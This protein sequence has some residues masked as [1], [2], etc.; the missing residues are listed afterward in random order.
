[1]ELRRL[2]R[3]D[4]LLVCDDVGAEADEQMKKPAIMKAIQDSGNDDESIKI[5]WEVIQEPRERE[6][7][8]RERK[9]QERKRER[10]QKY[11]KEK[12]A[13][14]KQIQYF[15][16]LKEQRQR[17]SENSVGSTEQENEE[18]S[19]GFS[20]K[21]D[22]KSSACEI[23]CTFIGERKGLAAND[24]LVAT[25]AVKG[26]NESDEVL[27]QQSTV[28]TARPAVNEL[29]QSPRVCVA[30]NVNKVVK[31]IQNNADP[32]D[33]STHVE[34]DLRAEG[35]CQLDDAV[36]GSTQDCEPLSLRED[37]CIV[38]GSVQRSASL[39]SVEL[40]ASRGKE[41][42][43]L[44]ENLSDCAGRRPIRADEMCTGQHEA[45][46][47]GMKVSA[48][49]KRRE[50]KRRNDQNAHFAAGCCK[51][52]SLPP[53]IIFLPNGYQDWPVES[54]PAKEEL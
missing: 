27:C 21:A 48:R 28:E 5:A 4:L 1:M 31:E 14:E 54:F 30:G 2:A 17:L 22:E 39:E 44:K 3:L 47:D 16:Q 37:N 38:Q 6:R 23:G 36:E 20:P 24:A 19:G 45:P 35:K 13:L 42:L 10:E 32:T 29:A 43:D 33:T 18:V 52:S 53:A 8:E 49:K 50:K 12:A 51:P 46:E 11:E 7:R 40:S 15:Q 26:R 41:R 9:Y 25:E 34:S